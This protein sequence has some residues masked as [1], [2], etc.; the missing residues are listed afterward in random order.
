MLKQPNK[1]CMTD[2][3]NELAL[4]GPSYLGPRHCE[5]H[6]NP[7]TEQNL[8]ERICVSCNLLQVLNVDNKCVFCTPGE[9]KTRRLAKQGKVRDFLKIQKDNP[10]LWP[11]IMKWVSTDTIVEKGICGKERPD[12]LF[13]CKTHFIVVE[14]DEHQHRNSQCACEQTRMINVTQSLD[15][16]TFWIRFNPD[17]WVDEKGHKHGDLEDSRWNWTKRLDVLWKWLVYATTYNPTSQ[18]R[19][20]LHVAYLFFDGWEQTQK[21]EDLVFTELESMLL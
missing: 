16:P 9:F 18:T 13:D 6:H 5:T 3:C 12:F 4:Y 20:V 11:D 8:V 19:W 1:K 2:V 15:M 14:C 17:K 7:Q 10:I 21:V